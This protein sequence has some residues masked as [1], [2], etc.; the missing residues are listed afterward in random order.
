MAY[1]KTVEKHVHT[2][3]K[4]QRSSERLGRKTRI[5]DHN[6]TKRTKQKTR[7][8]IREI[9]TRYSGRGSSTLLDE[10]RDLWQRM[11]NSFYSTIGHTQMAYRSSNTIS[12]VLVAMGIIFLIQSIALIWIRTP[13]EIQWSVLLGGLSLASFVSLFFTQPQKNIQ[14][15]VATALGNLAQIQMIYKLYSLQFAAL[16]DGRK[17]H[18][19]L[20]EK[21]TGFKDLVKDYVVMVQKYIEDTEVKAATQVNVEDNTLKVTTQI[22]ETTPNENHKRSEIQQALDSNIPI[23]ADR[24]NNPSESSGNRK[25]CVDCE[26]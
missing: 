7:R 10:T 5:G 17:K 4:I 13:I 19:I 24:L 21:S 12:Y 26:N 25:V 9:K 22:K 2:P 14:A 1:E 18:Y 3:K 15:N 11:D 8:F 6:K 23:T 16:A 20:Y